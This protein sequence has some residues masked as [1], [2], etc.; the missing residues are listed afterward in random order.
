MTLSVGKSNY[1]DEGVKTTIDVMIIDVIM[2]RN[3]EEDFER[4]LQEL[5]E[6]LENQVK[7]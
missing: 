2:I 5:K 4:A 7:M 6:S 1:K 3:N